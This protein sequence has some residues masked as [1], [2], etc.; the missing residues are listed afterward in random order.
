MKMVNMIYKTIIYFISVLLSAFTIS[1]INFNNVFK[2]NH[3]IEAKI[4]VIILSFIMGYLLGSFII[5]FLSISK[6][7]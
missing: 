3:I 5:E 7:L 4:F 6:I 2:T 1:G